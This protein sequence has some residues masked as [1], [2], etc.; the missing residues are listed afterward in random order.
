MMNIRDEELITM[1]VIF[2][3]GFLWI[4]ID[5]SLGSWYSVFGMLYLITV[6][7]GKARYV[8]ILTKNTKIIESIIFSCI[9]AVAWVMLGNTVLQQSLFATMKE[10]STIPVISG[11]LSMELLIYGIL[12]PIVETMVFCSFAVVLW[13]MVVGLPL[14]I[15]WYNTKSPYFYKMLWVC[16][17]VGV[18][19]SLFHLQARMA[20]DIALAIDALFFSLS[21][22]VVF[23]RKR[24]AEAGIIHA[25]INSGVVLG[26]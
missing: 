12:I 21:T 6:W 17:L 9:L 25:I 13:S 16:I 18:S 24:I 20:S 19:A 10:S 7:S 14:P 26:G 4:N 3:M 23:Y 11:G 5:P 2:I 8:E 15:R 1:S 22:L